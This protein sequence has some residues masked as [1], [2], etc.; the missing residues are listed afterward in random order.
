VTIGDPTER[1]LEAPASDPA[2]PHVGL[3]SVTRTIRPVAKF[4]V[5][6]ITRFLSVESASSVLLMGAAA[7]ALGWAN[8][9][10]A[11]GYHALWHATFPLTVPL[12]E[13]PTLHFLV[14][15]V[16]MAFFF[17]VV[18]LEIR[19][20]IHCGELADFKR[21]TLPL[22]AALGGMVAP[23]LIYVALNPSAPTLHGWGVPMATD[24][25]FAVGVLA[26][27]GSRI[28]AGLR[29]LLLA[30][31]VID[32]I[33]GILVIA[34]FYS[35]GLE[36]TG[37]AIALGAVLLVLGL[38]RLSVRSPWVYLAPGAML[39][40]GL[41]QAGIHPAL[42]GVTLGLLTPATHDHEG[43]P[44]TESVVHALH[45]YIA[46]FVMPVFA[47][48]NAGV[49]MGDL[50]L[51]APG[52]LQVMLGV[53]GGLLLG[54][55]VGILLACFLAVRS[56]LCSL[57][58]GVTFSGV[59]V[60]GIVAGIGFTVAIFVA[61]L[62]FANPELLSVAKLGVLVG[63]LLAGVLGYV[64]GRWLPEPDALVA[65]VT[66]EQAESSAEV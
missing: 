26:L 66:L 54:K 17:L 46:F 42:A 6:P 59:A 20:E 32:D 9:P 35:N 44:P 10:F 58:R 29:I 15:D 4:V 30:L 48:A 24:I 50:D 51:G 38:R 19:R 60:V 8:S 7:I 36:F 47:L 49:T 22:V 56:G 41:Y 57:P 64:V 39:W 18:G 40:M 53:G 28:P 2:K 21:A 33:G 13:K 45:P 5:G 52:A 65:G 37:L 12:I 61:S 31:A 55:P 43:P 63:S 16:L 27:L 62:A 3:A 25:A 1:P 11:H 34:A 14:N 23:A